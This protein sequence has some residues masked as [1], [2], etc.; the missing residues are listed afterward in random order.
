M[1]VASCMK[2]SRTLLLATM[3]T[4]VTHS[5]TDPFIY[6]LQVLLY[7]GHISKQLHPSTTIKGT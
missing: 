2:A 6:E 3:G 7:Q 5:L 1:V 4:I